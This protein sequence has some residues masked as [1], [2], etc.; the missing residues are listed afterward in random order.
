M[1]TPKTKG[2]VFSEIQREARDWADG[3]KLQLSDAAAV[4][5][6]L[7][8]HPRRY[9]DYKDAPDAAPPETPK[10]AKAPTIDQARAN[11][12]FSEMRGGATVEDVLDVI[13]A[14]ARRFQDTPAGRGM[15]FSAAKVAI[16]EL[17]PE[18][19]LKYNEAR[20]AGRHRRS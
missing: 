3:K 11:L 12:Q 8:E 5:G 9:R 10:S 19:Q 2:L 7:D 1:S 14:E 6:Y 17:K 4:A 15:S 13:D 20:R 18:L 16:N